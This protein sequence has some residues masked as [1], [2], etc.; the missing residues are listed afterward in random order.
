L[1]LSLVM[2]LHK[3]DVPFCL[4]ICTNNCF[5][6]MKMPAFFLSIFFYYYYYYYFISIFRCY[7]RRDCKLVFHSDIYRADPFWLDPDVQSKSSYQKVF[8]VWVW[9]INTQIKC[10]NFFLNY[11]CKF[12]TWTCLIYMC[13]IFVHSI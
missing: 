3:F 8:K 10:E 4:W 7:L 12:E 9:K 6:I 5:H 2:I 1:Y 11:C 13:L